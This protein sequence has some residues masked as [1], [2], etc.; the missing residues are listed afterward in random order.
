MPYEPPDFYGMDEL[1][2][3]DERMIRDSVR[4]WVEDRVLPIIS[5]HY[6]A[7]TFPTELIPQML[8]ITWVWGVTMT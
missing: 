8:W 2:T 5:D 1:L 4:G 3:E 7:G 6:L